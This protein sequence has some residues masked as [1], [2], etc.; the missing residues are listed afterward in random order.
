MKITRRPSPARRGGFT[1]IEMLVVIAIIAILVALTA[2]AVMRALVVGPRVTA[3]AEITQFDNGVLAFQSQYGVDY[4]P[5]RIMLRKFLGDYYTDPPTMKVP[6]SQLDQDSV[7]YLTRVFHRSGQKFKANWQTRGINWHSSWATLKGSQG[8]LLEGDQCLVFF[9]GGIQVT[10]P[11]GS[12]GFST[13]D[14]NPDQ[15]GGDRRSYYEFKSPRLIIAHTN[16]AFFSYAD[17]YGKNVPYAYFSAY[18]KDN[19]YN[20]YVVLLKS[21]D[22]ATL[23][24]WPYAEGVL[25][26]SNGPVYRYLKHNTYQVICAGADGQFGPGTDL[27]SPIPPGPYFYTSGTVNNIPKAGI[28]DQANF[29]PGMLSAGQ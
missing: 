15:P 17:A 21:S 1:L 7:D 10:N 22:C 27:T 13:D 3:R 4:F 29:A 11:N 2:A 12:M 16:S 19:G 24:V 9:L 14:A 26:S 18:G 23:K 20:P 25:N 6:K 8:E 28:D 5:S